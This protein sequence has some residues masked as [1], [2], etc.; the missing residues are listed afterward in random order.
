MSLI[1]LYGSLSVMERL[2]TELQLR[3]PPLDINYGKNKK[4]SFSG[5]KIKK[6]CSIRKDR[7][8]VLDMKKVLYQKM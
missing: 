5:W 4:V 8:S 3:V 2:E 7:Q 1:T 6:K